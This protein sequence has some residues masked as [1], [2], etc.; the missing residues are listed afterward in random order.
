MLFW[1]RPPTN[2]QPRKINKLVWTANLAV[3]L[4]L[5]CEQENHV[6]ARLW[7]PV[8][9]RVTIFFFSLF[10]V[11]PSKY[12]FN[13]LIGGVLKES[14][15]LWH[16]SNPPPAITGDKGKNI[17]TVASMKLVIKRYTSTT[18]NHVRLILVGSRL[19]LQSAWKTPSPNGC[20]LLQ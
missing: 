8:G 10:F 17:G 11:E 19:L 20:Q 5:P 12:L 18:N 2:F 9:R 1:P 14:T 3:A 4:V 13:V 15:R 16:Q 7:F 6:C